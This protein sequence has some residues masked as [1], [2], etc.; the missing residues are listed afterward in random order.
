VSYAHK[1]QKSDFKCKEEKKTTVEKVA[2]KTIVEKK[3]KEFLLKIDTACESIC[4]TS[5]V[6]SYF[7]FMKYVQSSTL[8]VIKPH[9]PNI[10]QRPYCLLFDVSN[11]LGLTLKQNVFVNRLG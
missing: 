5:R 3:T 7:V 6:F 9:T 4:I 11:Q 10:L 8:F 2:Q 1:T